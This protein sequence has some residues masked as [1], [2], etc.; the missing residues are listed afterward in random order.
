V[1]LTAYA[2]KFSALGLYYVLEELVQGYGGAL[3]G[4][5]IGVSEQQRGRVLSTAIFARWAAA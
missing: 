1:V 2:I 4:G 3:S 5:E